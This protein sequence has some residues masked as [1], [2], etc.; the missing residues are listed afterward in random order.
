MPSNSSILNA[1]HP[2]FGETLTIRLNESI[3]YG[4]SCMVRLLWDREN[5]SLS[6]LCLTAY[7]TRNSYIT[8]KKI[9]LSHRFEVFQKVPSNEPKS[10]RKRGATTLV[11]AY[12]RPADPA[13]LR[14]LA[15]GPQT[16]RL[17]RCRAN[18]PYSTERA[19]YSPSSKN[20]VNGSKRRLILIGPNLTD[21]IF[22]A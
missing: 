5:V 14:E 18:A 22:D 6:H 9:P 15:G 20:L 12:A 13:R 11:S 2:Y 17:A 21:N 10:D 3:R 7:E 1:P 8:L 4:V 19:E 16:A